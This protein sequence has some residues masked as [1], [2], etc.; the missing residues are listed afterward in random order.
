MV[1]VRAVLIDLREQG[2]CLRGGGWS[3]RTLV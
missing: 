1:V 2:G 3:H